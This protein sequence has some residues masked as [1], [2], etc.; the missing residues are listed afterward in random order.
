M[1]LISMHSKKNKKNMQF[2]KKEEK[3]IREVTLCA[4][5]STLKSNTNTQSQ[6]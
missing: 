5:T 2:R 6:I 1:E 4:D 3:K